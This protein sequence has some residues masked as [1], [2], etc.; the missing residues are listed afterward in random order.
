M[1]LIW[2]SHI[3]TESTPLY[4]GVNDVVIKAD[5]S[6]VAG[7]SCNT[8]KISLN[9]HAGTHVDAP[10]HFIPH[11]TGVAEYPPEQWIFNS[12]KLMD[13]PTQAGELIIPEHFPL[14]LTT[15]IDVDLLLIRTDFEQYRQDALYWQNGPGLAPELAEFLTQKFP[16]LRAIGLD[17]ISISSLAHREKGREAHRAFL[18]GG[19]L[20]FED[21]SLKMV[22]KDFRLI[23]VMAFPL[24][25]TGGDGAPCTIIGCS[26]KY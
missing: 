26:N 13:I 25:F 9:S 20:L 5:R 15:E 10:Y 24:R 23:Q 4:A 18:G 1:K 2:L 17:C 22:G 16:N 3:I 11:G 21:M 12:P 7:D 6:M 14:A 8:S 19:L